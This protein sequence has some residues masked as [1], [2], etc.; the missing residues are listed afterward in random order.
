LTDGSDDDSTIRSPVGGG[1]PAANGT[2]TL[3]VTNPGEERPIAIESV[4]EDLAEEI[5]IEGLSVS[6][7]TE[8]IEVELPPGSRTVVVSDL[9]LPAVATDTSRAVAVE[10]A[11]ILTRW[12]GP[13]AFVIAGDGF[14]ML[15]GPP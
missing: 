7:I 6:Q 12:T 2:V 1:G 3:A 5:A 13:G 4:T 11:A 9:H 10:L 14:E 15:A 8:E